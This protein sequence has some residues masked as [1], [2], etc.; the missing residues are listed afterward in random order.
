MIFSLF[1]ISTNSSLMFVYTYPSWR[2]IHFL[3]YGVLFF[4]SLRKFPAITFEHTSAF[5]LPLLLRLPSITLKLLRVI[6]M[7]LMLSAFIFIPSP[8]A[9]DWILFIEL[10]VSSLIL[11]SDNIFSNQILYFSILECPLIIWWNSLSFHHFCL[12]LPLFS[13][14]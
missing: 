5:F 9:T 13:W 8:C 4:I 3:N 10:S 12:S 2:I 14:I 6:H 1:L 11:T 7:F